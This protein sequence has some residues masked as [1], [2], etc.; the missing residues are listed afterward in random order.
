[1]KLKPLILPSSLLLCGFAVFLSG[2][3]RTFYV[4]ETMPRNDD[5]KKL[6]QSYNEYVEWWIGIPVSLFMKLM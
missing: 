5:E 1:M 6:I 3:V 4:G 2:L